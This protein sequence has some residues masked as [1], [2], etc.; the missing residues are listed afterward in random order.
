MDYGKIFKNLIFLASLSGLVYVNDARWHSGFFGVLFL[1]IYFWWVGKKSRL[2]LT[3]R[4]AFAHNGLTKILG[5]FFV[6]IGWSWVAGA[7]IVFF[8]FTSLVLAAAF[9]INGAIFVFLSHKIAKPE[10]K[11]DDI[12]NDEPIAEE[13]PGAKFGALA[14]LV[15]VGYGFY[16]LV[17]SQTG[18]A[19][20]SPWQTISSSYIFIFF[21]SA[22]ILGLLIFSHLRVKT[23][24]LFLFLQTL[25]LHSYLPLT[26]KL[27]YGADQWR[28]IGNEQRLLDRKEFKPAELRA[29]DFDAPKSQITN[30]KFQ[31][32]SK[33]QNLKIK[34]GQLSYGNFW[35]AN[36]LFAKFFANDLIAVNK[37]LMPILWSIIFP[38]LLF[39]IGLA[40]G[41][42]RRNSLFFC[43]LGLL[44]FAWQAAGSFTLPVNWGFLVWLFLVVL[45]LKRLK[46]PQKGQLPV[47]I[48]AGLGS[49]FGY[50]LYFILFWLGWGV[51]EVIKCKVVKFK[52][53][54][55]V[56]IS[57]VVIPAIELFSGYSRWSAKIDWFGQI[58]QVLGN[59]SAYFLAAGPRPHDIDAGNIIFNQTPAY[60]FAP[61]LFTQWRWWLVVF[62]VGFFLI[63]GYGL[64]RAW[65]RGP[66]TVKWF[67]ILAAGLLSGY[68]ISMY[69]LSGGHLLARRLDAVLALFLLAM[70]FYGLIPLLPRGGEGGVAEVGGRVKQHK[71]TLAILILSLAIA[72]SYSLGPDTFTAS[73]NEY[74][75]AAY[76]WSKE[77]FAEKHCV[78]ADTYPLLALEAVSAKEIIGGG[79][80]IDAN[81]AQSER[82]GLIKQMNLAINNSLLTRT[83]ELTGA[84]HCWFIGD[85]KIFGQQ[86][87]LQGSTYKIFGDTAVIKYDNL[88]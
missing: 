37:W 24:L 80:P 20:F 85:A 53:V 12:Y 4:F 62:A 22:L 26:H 49:V 63:F 46:S 16:L 60:A 56:L 2:L 34:I 51:A 69:F 70:F 41:W 42:T 19:I 68:I 11:P 47:L 14:F 67:A 29:A 52:A 81:F 45:I 43:W 44:P 9:F 33:L 54:A 84:N 1:L 38:L 32:N 77:K 79:F 10:E 35:S 78:L 13:A 73:E 25:L 71:Y 55:L 72:A 86:G 36:V 57:L 30:P 15:L 76:V 64:A 28:H 83:V 23:L 58:R 59:F 27:L 74:Q 39:E 87:V 5:I 8:P 6:L 7:L 61:N 48:F 50:A 82:V 17:A 65:R 31:T 21:L 3:E 75:A 88:K 18:R 40:L 66:A